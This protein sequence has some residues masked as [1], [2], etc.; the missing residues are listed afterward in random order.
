MDL[1]SQRIKRISIADEVVKRLKDQICSGN[2]EV[3]E[4]LPT[5]GELQKTLG[6]GRSTIREALRVLQAMGLIE[7]KSGRGA[8]IKSVR[9]PSATSIE[10]WMV[11]NE[12]RLADL[13]EVRIAVE[14]QAVELAIQ[15][16]TPEQLERLAEIHNAFIQACEEQNSVKLAKLDEEFHH[17][18]FAAANNAFL[19]RLGRIISDA[20][21]TFRNHSFSHEKFAANALRPHG[22]ILSAI[23]NKATDK[24]ISAMRN[25]MDMSLHDLHY[26]RKAHDAKTDS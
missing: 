5:E 17:A 1:G 19:S 14:A 10:D 20:L 12:D 25:H 8:F 3:G 2:M 24:A 18:I 16:G 23:T 26:A 6:V 21:R 22:E 4:K 13:M 11:E 7:M 9:E 15:R